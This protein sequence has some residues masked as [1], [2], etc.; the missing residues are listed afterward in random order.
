MVDDA[1][2][3]GK[4]KTNSEIRRWYLERITTIV[5]LNQAWIRRGL[6][7]RDRA[8]RAWRIRHEA[9]RAARS[10]MG[11]KRERELLRAR[12]TIKN[13]SPDGPS[14]EFLVARL[15]EVGIEGDDIYEAIIAGSHRTDSELNRLLGL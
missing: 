10:M 7:A 12:D 5:E 3:A 2:K 9:R 6:P 1:S 14:F 4:H 11:D 8:E 15:K 13:G